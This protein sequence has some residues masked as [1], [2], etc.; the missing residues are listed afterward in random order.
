MRTRAYLSEKMNIAK[1]SYSRLGEGFGKGT[2]GGFTGP[3]LTAPCSTLYIF[4]KY[5]FFQSVPQ[6]VANAAVK[7]KICSIVY[8]TSYYGLDQLCFEKIK[9][10]FVNFWCKCDVCCFAIHMW[11]KACIYVSM[12]VTSSLS[13]S[14]T[15][16]T[17]P[18]LMPLCL[19]GR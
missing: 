17:S 3:V 11:M 10:S 9:N 14:R 19:L 13:R 4:N 18:M 5:S 12:V 2:A 1:I 6:I 8:Q 7:V 15:F 16:E